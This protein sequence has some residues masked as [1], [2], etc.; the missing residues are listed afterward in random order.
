M[1]N[2]ARLVVFVEWV[3]RSGRYLVV[4]DDHEFGHV[5][6]Q[7]AKSRGWNAGWLASGRGFGL[8]ERAIAGREMLAH[9]LQGA[10]R[11]VS[12][13]RR[14]LARKAQLAWRRRQRPLRLDELRQ[15]DVLLTVW[16]RANTFP[17]DQN[18][19]EEFN[20][21]HLPDLLRKAG[22]IVAYLVYPLTYVSPFRTIVANTIAAREPVAL[23]EDF[24]P[25]W[26][27]IAAAFAGWRLPHQIG[28]LQVLGID[29]TDLLR[30]EARRDRR[31]SVG[32]EATLLAHVGRGLAR[33]GI[34][35]KTL[36]HLYEA[37]PW[38]K[39]LAHGVRQHLPSTRIAG[40]Q[41]APFAWNYLSF[42][43][44]RESLGQA[45]IPDLLLTSGEAYAQWFQNA[46][47]APDHLGVVGALR[48]EIA[49][50]EQVPSGRAVLCCTGIEIDEAVELATKAAVAVE[51]TGIPLIVNFHPVTDEAFR[52]TVRDRVRAAVRQA[53]EDITF[54]PEPMRKLIERAGT[55]LYMS[56]AACFEAV[57]ARRRAIY[58]TRDLALDYDKLPEDMALRCGSLD[59]L[60][61][62]L[63]NFDSAQETRQSPAALRRW[64]APVADVA[65]LRQ[66]L[67]PA[68]HT[69]GP[70]HSL[71]VGQRV[72]G[73]NKPVE[74][75]ALG[76]GGV[77]VN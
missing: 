8:R 6:L 7:Q 55:V 34:R 63:L 40:V 54:S 20:F 35:P 66:L 33:Q 62:M 70:V 2:L 50:H 56:S 29:A 31:L 16:G 4:V 18:L 72:A 22:F 1:V 9:A 17:Q 60:R 32:V 28:Q 39:L 26:A 69:S 11:R 74:R 12:A 13:I 51:G 46:G 64:L 30:L 47:V 23:I 25:W 67:S 21:G 43:P 52:A 61:D 27:I 65:T 19:M 24:I 41:H 76:D 5:L 53:F 73:L 59:A 44:S 3:A 37:Q 71:R 42:F 38:E 36:L 10:R 45:S 14:F 48:Y 49:A 15:A 68:N 75:V 57:L 58:V 77:P